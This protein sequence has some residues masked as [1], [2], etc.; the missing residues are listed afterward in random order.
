MRRLLAV[1][2]VLLGLLACACTRSQWGAAVAGMAQG[3][4]A[5]S[6]APAKLMLFGG[7][8]HKTYL[9][10]LNCSQYAQ[11]SILNSYG[12]H[13]S[14]YNSESIWNP[15]SEFGSRYSSYGACNAYASDPPV[16][17]DSEGKYYGRLT[18]N[19]Y[20]PEIGVGKSYMEWLKTAVCKL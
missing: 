16:I 5:T 10:C 8:G 13:G 12:D 14:Q 3:A 17:V 6:Q 4:A 20:H 18:M 15:Y 7:D 11:D 2:V 9:G 1:V 19:A